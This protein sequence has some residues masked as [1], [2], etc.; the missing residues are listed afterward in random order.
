MVG[1]LIL[2]RNIWFGVVSVVLV[3]LLAAIGG[4]AV[5]G[6]RNGVDNL[7]RTYVLIKTQYLRPTSTAKLMEGAAKG[8]VST[9]NDPY[10]VYLDQ[11]DFKSLD[12]EIEGAFGGIGVEIGLNDNKQLMVVTPLPGTPAAKAGLKSGDLFA[13]IGGKSTAGMN[14]QKAA[15]LLRGKVGSS[16]T[17][18]MI[19]P[20]QN[21]YTYTVAIK[22]QKISTVVVNGKILPEHQELAYVQV[23][24]FNQTGT[25]S[26]LNQALTKLKQSGYRGMILDLRGNPGGDLQTAVEMASTFLKKGPVVRIVRRNGSQEVWQ[27]VQVSN[28]VSVPLVVLVDNGSASASE[29]VAG[30]IKDTGSGE[31][32]G[33]RTFGKGVVQTIYPLSN[34]EGVKLTTD[35]YLTPN[36][37]DINKKGILPDVVV[38]Q[39]SGAKSDLQLDRAVQILEQ[40]LQT[41]G[42]A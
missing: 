29:I 4:L 38:T 11:E 6:A 17:V 37:H 19:R 39:P 32:V 41:A 28:R 33:T 12:Q 18:K 34:D 26:Q 13:A 3:A 7:V 1:V 15:S 31:L 30:A 21:N 8:M 5:W 16:V 27:R 40:K 24:Q 42:A 35:K 2:K 36:G 20:Q 22:R 9:L 14:T 10:S 23:M 25:I